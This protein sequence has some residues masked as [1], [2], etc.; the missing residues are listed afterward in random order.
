MTNF[1]AIVRLVASIVSVTRKRCVVTDCH[2]RDV[3]R[4]QLFFF[5]A[6]A[7]DYKCKRS[8]LETSATSIHRD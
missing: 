2:N 5:Y 8:T 7:N 1:A 4:K 3:E 6:N